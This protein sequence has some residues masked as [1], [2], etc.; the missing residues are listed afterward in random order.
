MKKDNDRIREIDIWRIIKV[1]WHRLWAVILVAALG[2][3]LAFAYA[4]YA[5]KPKYQASTLM[6][7]NT[8]DLSVGNASIISAASLSTAQRLVD[9]YVVIL[10]SRTTLEAVIEQAGLQGKYSYEALKSMIHAE[11]V[12]DTE[13]F[14]VTVVSTNAQEAANIANT[15]YPV[16]KEKIQAIMG[17]ES[18]EMVDRAVPNPRKVSPNTTRYTAIGIIVGAV[19]CAVLLVLIDF[20]DDVIRS[21]E[22]VKQVIDAPILAAIPDLLDSGHGGRGYGYGYGNSTAHTTPSQTKNNTKPVSDPQRKGG[23]RS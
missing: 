18:V 20:F 6:Y 4:S 23:T 9:T 15:I 21:E 7:V 22:D 13:I 17:V 1:V 5:I 16:L 19:A 8:G 2:G 3:T 10:N 11:A 14:Q 12:N